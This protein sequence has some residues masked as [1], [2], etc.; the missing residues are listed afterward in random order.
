MH[1]DFLNIPQAISV[2]QYLSHAD[3]QGEGIPDL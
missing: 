3:E 1:M 2:D